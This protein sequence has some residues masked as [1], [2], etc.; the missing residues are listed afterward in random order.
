MLGYDIEDDDDYDF[1]EIKGAHGKKPKLAAL[2]KN[3]LSKEELFDL[4]GMEYLQ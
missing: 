1:D 4:L 2:N 3:K